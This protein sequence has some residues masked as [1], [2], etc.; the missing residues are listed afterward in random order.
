VTW[1]FRHKV[2]QTCTLLGCYTVGSGNFLM[3]FWDNLLVP[4]SGD[5]ALQQCCSLY[6]KPTNQT[7]WSTVL[8]KLTCFQLV[9]K[10]LSF[11]GSWRFIT[12]F[13]RAWHLSIFW[14]R[15]IQSIPPHTASFRFILILSS[16]LHLGFQM[17][18]F[19]QVSPQNAVCTPYTPPYVLHAPP[20]SLFLIWSPE[21]YL[22]SST[23]H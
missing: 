1:G 23:D 17:V 2:E 14:A 16:H 5:T 22:V 3:T 21:Q 9:K 18:S 7:S 19:P 15:S 12:T 8:E 13:T 10:F 4:S 20:I 11:Y 6:Y